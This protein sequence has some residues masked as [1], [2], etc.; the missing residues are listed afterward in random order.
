MPKI[1]TNVLNPVSPD[2]VRLQRDCIIHIEDGTIREIASDGD[3]DI[4]HSD[5]IC[6]PG[7]IDT[8]VH[9]S[10]YNV[11]GMHAPH[12]IQ[13]LEKYIFPEEAKSFNPEYAYQVAQDFFDA[14]IEAGTTTAVLYVSASREATDIAF[15]VAQE[16]GIRAIIGKVMMDVN[17]PATLQEMPEKAMKDS[18]ALYDAWHERSSL[19]GYIFTPRFAPVCSAGMMR[20]IGKEASRRKAYIQTHLS[21]NLDEIKWVGELFPESKTYTDVYDRAGLLTEKTL[22]GHCIHLSDEEMAIIKERGAK[23][24]HCPDSNFFLKSGAF[25]WHRTEASGIDFALG[26]DVGA[27]TTLSMLEIMKMAIYRQEKALSPS[28]V[29]YRAT[30][31]GARVL[32]RQDDLGILEKGKQAD[33]V[34][35]RMRDIASRMGEELLSTMIYLP[36]SRTIESVYVHGNRISNT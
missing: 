21:E 25:P 14:L 28:E 17:S 4:D 27:G 24:T 31:G 3:F 13:W 35:V 32:S 22:L 7:L 10:Q 9:L 12:L 15:Q 26:S 20:E 5:C 18:L 23:I 34:F 16:K 36:D 29:F 19:L 8:H 33:M 30:V 6:I 11:R 1:K 2:S